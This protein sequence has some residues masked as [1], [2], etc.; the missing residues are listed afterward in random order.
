MFSHKS[1]LLIRIRKGTLDGFQYPCVIKTPF[2]MDRSHSLNAP[3]YFDGS[4]YA[5]WKVRMHA[6]LC[7]INKTVWDS[8]KNGWMRL[9]IAKA[10][11]NKAA[12]A[13]TKANNKVINA[14]FYGVSTNESH[15]IS[16]VKTTKGIGP[17]L[18]SPT[19]EPRRLRTPSFKCSLLI[20][21]MDEK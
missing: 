16:H 18:R 11:W 3:P 19:K 14:I 8:I 10:E 4:N 2:E 12:L 9:T 6:F 5:F 17:F 21:F 20:P 1:E 15:R 7:A 13:L